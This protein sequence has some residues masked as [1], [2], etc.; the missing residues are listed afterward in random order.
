M[1]NIGVMNTES[2]CERTLSC[3]SLIVTDLHTSLSRE[4][5]RMLTLLR[6]NVSLMEYMRKEYD[7]LHSRIVTS[8]TR[9]NKDLCDKAEEQTR[10][11]VT[12]DD[13]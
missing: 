7:G 3:A 12:M 8:E 11:S 9:I 1:A 6:M 2:F 4:D 10:E 13:T 5:V